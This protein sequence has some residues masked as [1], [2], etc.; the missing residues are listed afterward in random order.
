M[1]LLLLPADPAMAAS[2]ACYVGGERWDGGHYL[3]YPVRKGRMDTVPFILRKAHKGL[4]HSEPFSLLQIPIPRQEMEEFYQTWFFF[5]LAAEFLGLNEQEDGRRLVDAAIAQQELSELYRCCIREENDKSYLT[6]TSILASTGLIIDRIRQIKPIKDME[7][8]INYLRQ[9]LCLT[10]DMLASPPPKG[11][12]KF[13]ES[14]RY[15]ILGLAELFRFEIFTGFAFENL[16]LDGDLFAI[17]TGVGFAANGSELERNLLEAGHC[18]SD[19]EVLR[20][21]NQINT[22][23]YI[24]NLK[25]PSVLKNHSTCTAR[26]CLAA[27]IHSN[28]YRLAHATEACSCSTIHVDFKAIEYILKDRA[29][30]PVLSVSSWDKS[31]LDIDVTIEKYSATTPYIAISHVRLALLV[32]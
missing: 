18:R 22:K 32:F 17:R 8:R 2:K 23:Y 11:D 16:N 3:T 5:G 31:V 14:F 26:R 25:I 10:V 13:E 27:Q 21:F 9:C 19:V 15:S 1:D 28:G 20:Q 6:G 30:Y 24:S 29:S 7:I 4:V 12:W